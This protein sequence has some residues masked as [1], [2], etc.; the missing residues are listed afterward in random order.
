MS[1]QPGV[2]AF[3]GHPARP[4]AAACKHERRETHLFAQNMTWCKSI[5]LHQRI[6]KTRLCFLLQ[7]WANT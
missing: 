3:P 5:W 7:H 1:P 6:T 4:R 2:Q